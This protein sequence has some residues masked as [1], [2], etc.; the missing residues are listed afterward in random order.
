ME[1]NGEYIYGAEEPISLLDFLNKS[2]D[3]LRVSFCHLLTQMFII[4][5]FTGE[6]F[7]VCNFLR[8]DENKNEKIEKKLKEVIEKIKTIDSK[9]KIKFI[10]CVS[11]GEFLDENLKNNMDSWN[12]RVNDLP[13]YWLQDNSHNYKCNR[14]C[15]INRNL[16]Y[17][18]Q[19]FSIAEIASET[20][21]NQ[22][23]YNSLSDDS[24]CIVDI[25]NEK[26]ALEISEP[27]IINEIKKNEK[28]KELSEYLSHKTFI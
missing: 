1:R 6:S 9:K 8:K 23:L 28:L 19:N 15:L 7:P 26:F 17:C 20:L 12:K 25:M 11:D 21:I 14:N 24:I 13:F 5:I 16:M 4:C 22:E 10:G 2:D 27:K 18:E 3:E